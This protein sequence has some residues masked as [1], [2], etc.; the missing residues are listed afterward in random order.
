[1]YSIYESIP[2]NPPED[3]LHTWD[4]EKFQQRAD[5]LNYLYL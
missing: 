1:M 2:R 5:K 4:M 3:E